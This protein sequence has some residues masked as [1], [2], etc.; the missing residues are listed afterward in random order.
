M[1]VKHPKESDGKSYGKVAPQ[2]QRQLREI[3]KSTT[4]S[5]LMSKT[6]AFRR[7]YD[8]KRA[9]G[10]ADDAAQRWIIRA[11][12]ATVLGVWKTGKKYDDKY[13]EVTRKQRKDA[14][15]EV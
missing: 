14:H 6:N 3:F 15:S 5:V 13:R 1:L 11:L 9:D 7:E 4:R 12:A 10:M 8:Q 2:G